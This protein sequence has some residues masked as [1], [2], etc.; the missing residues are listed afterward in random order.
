[1]CLG[2]SFVILMPTPTRSSN[3]KNPIL[4]LAREGKDQNERASQEKFSVAYFIECN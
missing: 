4:F 1:M 3:K 2:F